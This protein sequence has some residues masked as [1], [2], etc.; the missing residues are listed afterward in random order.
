M[1]IQIN[2]GELSQ[3]MAINNASWP[4]YTHLE[5]SSWF[6]IGHEQKR[7]TAFRA[8]LWIPWEAPGWSLFETM[9][10]PQYL[11]TDLRGLNQCHRNE[12]WWII[13]ERRKTLASFI[14]KMRVIIFLLNLP[15]HQFII[16][17]T[18]S[19]YSTFRHILRELLPI[20]CASEYFFFF[21]HRYHI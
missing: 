9:V 1:I 12:R 21:K 15:A 20:V 13:S 10:N 6:W 14:E 19:S 3:P 8:Y 4:K 11:C 2:V 16:C 18:L 17:D 5:R 7:V